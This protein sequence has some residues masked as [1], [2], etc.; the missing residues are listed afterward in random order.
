MNAPEKFVLPD[1]ESSADPRQSASQRVEI[2]GLRYPTKLRAGNGAVV[3]M[4]ATLDTPVARA[5]AYTG[6]AAGQHKK[7]G[8]E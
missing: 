1:V 7:A 8:L 2:K 6:D 3:A 5:A 4:I